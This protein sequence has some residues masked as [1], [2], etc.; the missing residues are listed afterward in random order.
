MK[1]A[2][3]SMAIDLPHVA[4]HP[5][6]APFRGVLTFVDVA[7]DRA[8]AGAQG[9]RVLLTRAAAERALPSLLGMGLDYAPTLDRHDSRRKVGVITSAEISPP[10]TAHACFES[11]RNPFTCASGRSPALGHGGFNREE[12]ARAAG[13]GMCSP[14]REPWASGEDQQVPEGRQR[15]SPATFRMATPAR[16]DKPALSVAVHVRPASAAEARIFGASAIAG[17][18]T[19]ARQMP[20]SHDR[21][22]SRVEVAGYIFARDFP[23]LMRE[24]RA[25]SSRVDAGDFARGG[26]GMSY[27]IADAQIDDIRTAVWTVS[28]FVF[29]GAAVLRRDK[30]AYQGTWIELQ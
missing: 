3:E 14:R 13:A 27:E 4:G 2:L 21:A 1:I 20:D 10:L 7:S 12:S 23:E 22:T 28:D 30:A 5:N 15:F 18:L 9:H 11:T 19:S 17:H 24:L 8:P 6:R 25:Q 16:S 29:T 26:L